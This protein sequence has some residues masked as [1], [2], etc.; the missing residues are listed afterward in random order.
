M[1]NLLEDSAKDIAETHGL[2]KDLVT[3]TKTYTMFIMFTVVIGAPLLFSISMQF[4]EIMSGMQG[5]GATPTDDSFGLGMSSG[6]ITI[7]P[8]FIFK[9]KTFPWTCTQIP[10]I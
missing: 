7:T 5:A 8:E 4:V 2:K 9:S 1:A 10:S 6:E 3:G